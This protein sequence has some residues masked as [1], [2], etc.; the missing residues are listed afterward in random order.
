MGY[1]CLTRHS[2]MMLRQKTKD[3]NS[4]TS[5]EDTK[6]IMKPYKIK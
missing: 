4:V 6:D 2:G 3:R 1:I 5:I